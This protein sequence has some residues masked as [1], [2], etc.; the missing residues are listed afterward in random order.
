MTKSPNTARNVTLYVRA[1]DVETWR[2]ARKY[3]NFNED[4]SLSDYLTSHLRDVVS[5]HEGGGQ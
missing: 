5:K 2:K 3:I 4:R 1:E